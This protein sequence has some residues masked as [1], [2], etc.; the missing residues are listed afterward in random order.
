MLEDVKK[1]PVLGNAFLDVVLAGTV[2]AT[3]SLAW[4]AATGGRVQPALIGLA[5]VT[6]GAYLVGSL[7]LGSSPVAYLRTV[8][9]RGSLPTDSSR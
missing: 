8:W 5:I 4:D 2:L 1:D 6:Y 9:R 3:A 7:R